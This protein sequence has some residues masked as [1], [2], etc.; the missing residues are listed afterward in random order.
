MLKF[1]NVLIALAVAVAAWFLFGGY[2]VNNDVKEK[3][4]GHMEKIIPPSPAGWTSKELPLGPTEE[5]VR[6][7]E[8]NLDTSD[9]YNR[10]FTSPDGSMS[11]VVYIS[12]WGA[13]KADTKQASAH[14]PD[15]CWVLNGWK[16][17]ENAM[18]SDLVFDYDGVRLIP[19]YYREMTFQSDVGRASRNVAF[20]HVYDGRRFDYGSS[21]TI[22]GTVSLSYIKYAFEAAFAGAPEQYFIRIDSACK[23][24]DLARQKGFREVVKSLGKL[25]LEE[26]SEN[27]NPEKK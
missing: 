18:R 2:S 10:E 5:V 23:F 3:P 20:W 11:F 14:T 9:Y 19:A 26:K 13:G 1:I 12:Y 21:N 25:V 15:R 8:K 27:A 6:S 24:E 7:V 16:S 17:D 22:Y 4:K